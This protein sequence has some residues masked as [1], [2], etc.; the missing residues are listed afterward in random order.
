MVV[1][2]EALATAETSAPAAVEELT[3]EDAPSSSASAVR[4]SE[5]EATGITVPGSEAISKEG[6]LYKRLEL[7]KQKRVL[8]PKISR[9]PEFSR[10]FRKDGRRPRIQC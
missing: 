1:P 4:T 3:Y 6:M 10:H 2:E 9:C 8:I 7:K 5:V